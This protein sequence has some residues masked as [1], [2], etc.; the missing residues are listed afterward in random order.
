MLKRELQVL[1]EL[2]S[3]EPENRAEWAGFARGFK[4]PFIKEKEVYPATGD[5]IKNIAIN[6][7][8]RQRTESWQRIAH[9]VAAAQK[10]K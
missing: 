6:P 5:V 3:R 4:N 9:E 1:D 8:I 10:A 7:P 2:F